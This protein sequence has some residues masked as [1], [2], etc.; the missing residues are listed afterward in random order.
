[1]KAFQTN[2]KHVIILKQAWAQS[3]LFV[4]ILVQRLVVGEFMTE[5]S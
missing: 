1:M 5:Y 2:S 3:F 4:I